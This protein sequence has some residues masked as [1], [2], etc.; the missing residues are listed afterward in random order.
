LA[1]YRKAHD[2]SSQGKFACTEPAEV[3]VKFH[4]SKAARIGIGV[5]VSIFMI[6]MIIFVA[7]WGQRRY[8]R[9]RASE[10]QAPAQQHELQTVRADELLVYSSGAPTE[11]CSLRSERTAVPGRL[12]GEVAEPPGAGSVRT[13]VVP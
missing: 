11:V 5:G 7:E 3:K 8:R 13:Q 6:Y 9:K 2:N 10:E 1:I 4:L 12:S